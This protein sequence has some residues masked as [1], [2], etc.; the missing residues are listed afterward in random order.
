MNRIKPTSSA[1]IFSYAGYLSTHAYYPKTESDLYNLAGQHKCPCCGAYQIYSLNDWPAYMKSQEGRKTVSLTSLCECGFSVPFYAVVNYLLD[2]FDGLNSNN[3]QHTPPIIYPSSKEATLFECRFLIHIGKYEYALNF[4]SSDQG[5]AL[6][7]FD[8]HYFKGYCHERMEHL[9]QALNEYDQ[10]L[11][12]NPRQGEAWYNKWCI[13]TKLGRI[14]EADFHKTKYEEYTLTTGNLIPAKH[15]HDI[16]NIKGQACGLNGKIQVID[17]GNKRSLLINQEVQSGVWLSHGQASDIP[18]NSDA[19]GLLLNGCHFQA[20]QCTTTGIVLGLGSGA[21]I[22]SLLANF[23]QLNLIVV[24]N[25]PCIVQMVLRHF[26]KIKPYLENHRLKIE[27]CDAYEFVK[28]VI[29][30]VQFIVIDLYQG[31]FEP[32]PRL[33]DIEFFKIAHTKCELLSVNLKHPESH[34]DANSLIHYFSWPGIELAHAHR[35]ESSYIAGYEIFHTILFNQQIKHVDEFIPYK[36]REDF[37]SVAFR[38]NFNFE[39]NRREGK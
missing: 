5:I 30:P 36:N 3:I 12:I 27:I 39:M 19:S 8:L 10:C 32:C 6:S 14:D 21:G 34:Y 13:L 11:T 16:Y 20:D 31:N 7:D 24:E 25:D 18:S 9:E 22:I 4:I 15:R 1:K 33:F 29:N 17:H 35:L 28:K 26:P 38:R 23:D 37:L 2:P